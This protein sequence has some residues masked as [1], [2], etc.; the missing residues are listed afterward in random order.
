[1][2]TI[3]FDVLTEYAATRLMDGD[4]LADILLEEMDGGKAPLEMRAEAVERGSFLTAYLADCMHHLHG[5][6]A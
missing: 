1:M 3:T 6:D 5:R 2:T 4:H